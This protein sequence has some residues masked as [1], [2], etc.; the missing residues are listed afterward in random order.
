[1]QT[2]MTVDRLWKQNKL[3][4]KIRM[5]FGQTDWLIQQSQHTFHFLN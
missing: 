5:Q 4:E 1:M 2:I 3:I